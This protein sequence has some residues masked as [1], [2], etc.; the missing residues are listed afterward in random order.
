MASG[1]SDKKFQKDLEQTKKYIK[2][3]VSSEDELDEE[4][5]NVNEQKNR[6]IQ[7]TRILAAYVNDFEIRGKANRRYRFVLFCFCICS[8][9]A[10][11]SLSIFLLLRWI[12][13]ITGFYKAQSNTTQQ[14]V[15]TSDSSDTDKAQTMDDFAV[16]MQSATEN[17]D[18]AQLTGII[19]QMIRYSIGES[20]D[21]TYVVQADMSVKNVVSLITICLTLLGSIIGL[22]KIITEYVFQKDESSNVIEIVKSMQSNDYDLKK[23]QMGVIT[24]KKA[25]KT[26]G[27]SSPVTPV[28]ATKP[29]AS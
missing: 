10:L 19:D 29:S 1:I 28:T 17:T 25:E 23:A 2:R 5:Y 3:R 21:T 15:E 27:T 7:N 24:D 18:Y 6:E 4:V 26:G 8:T 20:A 14:Q 9:F 16:L 11:I 12:P 22:L 13:L